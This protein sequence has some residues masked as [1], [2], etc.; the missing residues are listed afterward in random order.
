MF[1]ILEGPNGSGKTT[2]KN[3]FTTEPGFTTLFSPG[4]TDL[5]NY[6]RPVCRG[7]DQ[8]VGVDPHLQF[9]SFSTARTDE[10]LKIVHN[11]PNIIISDRWWTSTYVYQCMLQGFSVDFLEHTIHPKEQIDAVFILDAEPE[12]LI[13]RIQK[14]RNQ[15][16]SHKICTWTKEKE[17]TYQLREIYKNKLPTYLTSRNIKNQTINTENYTPEEIFEYVKEEIKKL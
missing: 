12:T 6:L 2:L 4:S 1:I 11:N 7:T 13:S 14:E 15:N 8:W 17:T 16:P 9:L 3:R 5:A 10:Y